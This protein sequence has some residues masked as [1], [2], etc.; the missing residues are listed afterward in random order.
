MVEAAL[1]A[2]ALACRVDEREAA[3]PA[4]AVALRAGEEPLFQS[5]GDRLRES[6]AD[7]TA[8]R[9]GVARA[10]EA[11]RLVRR[12]DL[13]VG[14]RRRRLQAWC[15]IRAHGSPRSKRM[16]QQMLQLT[17]GMR[18]QACKR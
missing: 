5:D 11:H 13:P 4:H 9:D 14:P 18:C 6:D 12:P 17:H 1:L 15:G 3:R 10:N 7:K 2:V 16:Q 8:R